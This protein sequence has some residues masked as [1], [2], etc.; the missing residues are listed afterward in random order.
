MT[1]VVRR[2]SAADELMGAISLLQQFFREEGFDTP[3]ETI[4]SH[5]R[6]MAGIAAC[7]LFLA[8]DGRAAVGVAT[9]SLEFGIEFG[10]SAE[11]GDLY[12]ASGWRGRGVSRMLVG[13]VENY[14]RDCGAAGYQVTVTPHAEDRH[15]LSGFYDRLGF[16]NEGRLI[17]YKRLTS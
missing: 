6:Q 3:P 12:V 17:R 2:L 9:V 11:M 7:G 8:E 4:A 1:V 14:L 13:A 5:V 16:T 15:G 10:W